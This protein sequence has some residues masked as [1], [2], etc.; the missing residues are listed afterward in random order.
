MSLMFWGSM[1]TLVIDRIGRKN[2]M[3][4]GA[5][6]QAICFSMAAMGLS[7]DTKAMSALAVTFIFLYYVFYVS[8]CPNKLERLLK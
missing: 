2:L 5:F 6:T 1:A 8:C 3:L 7:F 4:M